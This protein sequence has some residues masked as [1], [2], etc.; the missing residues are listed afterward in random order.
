MVINVTKND[1]KTCERCV[2]VRVYV[3]DGSVGQR[4]RHMGVVEM[5][6]K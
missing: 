3:L 5:H 1:K 6:L 4:S 2:E